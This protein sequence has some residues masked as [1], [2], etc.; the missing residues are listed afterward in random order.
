MGS[1][2]CDVIAIGAG[3]VLTTSLFSGPS[4]AG[5][6]QALLQHLNMLG[7]MINARYFAMLIGIIL[8]VI[9]LGRLA[10]YLHAPDALE[11]IKVI[12]ALCGGAFFITALRMGLPVVPWFASLG[13]GIGY[14][15]IYGFLVYRYLLVMQHVNSAIEL[16]HTW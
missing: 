6:S 2:V 10:T 3:L 4:A 8:F 13:F 14:L 15:V 7:L 12:F 16:Q 11:E 1:V 5:G 9:F